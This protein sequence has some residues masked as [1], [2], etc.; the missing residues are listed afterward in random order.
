MKAC[1]SKEELMRWMEN[2]LDTSEGLTEEEINGLAAAGKRVI[3][4]GGWR[5]N[6]S[7]A[8]KMMGYGSAD[9]NDM[10]L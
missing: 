1:N 8:W 6:V 5:G 2:A 9:I 4:D 10:Y 3:D 7:E